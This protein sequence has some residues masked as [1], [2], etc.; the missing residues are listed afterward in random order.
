MYF[1]KHFNGLALN[2]MGDIDSTFDKSFFHDDFF[3]NQF[4]H[5][6]KMLKNMMHE[7]DSVKN[8]YFRMHAQIQKNGDL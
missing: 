8:E 3:E 1:N 6:D 5:Q 4:M 7:M 2:R